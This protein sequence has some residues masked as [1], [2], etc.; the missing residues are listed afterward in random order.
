MTVEERFWSKV[1]KTNECWVWLGTRTEFGYGQ[2]RFEG[3]TR[4][5]HRVAWTLANGPVPNDRP[6][7]LH[8]CDNPPCVRPEHLFVGTLSDNSQDC[9]AKGRLRLQQSDAHHF[10]TENHRGK[11]TDEDVAAIRGLRHVYKAGHLARYF[12]VTPHHIRLL[13]NGKQR[14]HVSPLHPTAALNYL[15]ERTTIQ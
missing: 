9:A 1:D 4:K 11:L 8:R 3:H 12:P 6:N 5:A 2:F 14:T 7:V 10:G 13:W 15:T